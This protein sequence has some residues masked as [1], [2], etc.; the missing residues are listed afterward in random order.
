MSQADLNGEARLELQEL[1]P[2]RAEAPNPRRAPMEF[3]CS[4]EE[5][6]AAFVLGSGNS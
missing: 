2:S 6:L 3:S 1:L 4:I 5:N